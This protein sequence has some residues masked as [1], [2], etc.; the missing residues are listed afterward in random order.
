MQITIGH[1]HEACCCT[2]QGDVMGHKPR[3][4]TITL[5][6]LKQIYVY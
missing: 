1:E 5:L 4:Y 2:T 3:E 6:C